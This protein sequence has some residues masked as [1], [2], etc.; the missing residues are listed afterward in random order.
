MGRGHGKSP[1]G[2][3]VIIRLGEKLRERLDHLEALAAS[4][5]QS[6]AIGSTPAAGT[7]PPEAVTAHGSSSTPIHIIAKTLPAHHVSG[8][9]A[10]SSSAATPGGC[11]HLA[12]QPDD[13]PSA[14]RIWDSTTHIDPSLLVRDK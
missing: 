12:A 8:V 7:G 14:L 1:D 9:S 5:A 4:A 6:R 2:Q 11:Q 13:T 3:I 10:P